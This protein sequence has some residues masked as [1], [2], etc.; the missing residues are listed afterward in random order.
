MQV[1][2]KHHYQML[3]P[4]E[5]RRRKNAKKGIQFCMLVVGESGSGKTTFCN[6]ICNQEVFKNDQ[7]AFDP[8]NAHLSPGLEIVSRN[9]HLQEE[10]ATPISLDIVLIPGLGDNID[11]SKNHEIVVN[12][13][14]CQFDRVLNEEIRIK[15]NPNHVD[16]RP[17]VCLYFIRATSKG[18]RELDIQ[19]MKSLCD[20]VNI[21]PVISK[22]DLLTEREIAL[23]KR[24]IMEDIY[25]NCLLYTSR[26]V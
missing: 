7:N 25:M 9:F 8:Q 6:N 10:N 24:L 14:E 4:E 17:H 21:I 2:K 19:L 18:L 22:A 12:Y 1:K 23:N 16:T 13:L 3:S 26:C 11:N 5:I 15:R 20:K